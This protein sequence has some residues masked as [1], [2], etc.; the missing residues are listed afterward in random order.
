MCTNSQ[1][2][3]IST[4]IEV[5]ENSKDLSDIWVKTKKCERQ[6]MPEQIRWKTNVPV[7]KINLA[8]TKNNSLRG[9]TISTCSEEKF[10]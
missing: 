10:I 8:T 1:Y 4:V 7:F 3:T 6:I 2:S 9:I 5:E